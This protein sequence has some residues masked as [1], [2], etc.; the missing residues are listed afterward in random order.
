M[1]A[2][3]NSRPTRSLDC[4]APTNS[5]A[6]SPPRARATSRLLSITV[7]VIAC[8]QSNEGGAKSRANPHRAVQP[9]I[10]SNTAL[11]RERRPGVRSGCIWISRS[12]R[13]P[14]RNSLIGDLLVYCGEKV[15]APAARVSRVA[16]DVLILIDALEWEFATLGA[17]SVMVSR[18]EN[19]GQIALTMLASGIG[20]GVRGGSEQ[21]SHWKVNRQ[22]LPSPVEAKVPM[23]SRRQGRFPAGW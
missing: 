1:L 8:S 22:L 13:H 23:R 19:L 17:A 18:G 7:A 16:G 4:K 9:S 15:G 6:A 2:A 3:P 10:R 21:D 20:P 11:N 5:P 14:R 12:G